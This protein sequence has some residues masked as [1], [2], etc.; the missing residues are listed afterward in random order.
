MLQKVILVFLLCVLQFQ[1][2]HS[3]Y[4]LIDIHDEDHGLRDAGAGCGDWCV[5]SSDCTGDPSCPHCYWFHCVK[6]EEWVDFAST[7]ISSTGQN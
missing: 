2:Y 5:G 6:N 4:I 1:F 7:G 3:R